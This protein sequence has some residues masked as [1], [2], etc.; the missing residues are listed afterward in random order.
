VSRPLVPVP[1]GAD[2]RLRDNE[3]KKKEETKAKQKQTMM[4]FFK[5][6]AA[7]PI[8]RASPAGPSSEP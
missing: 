2:S 3:A 5:K 1:H 4:S 7:S 6:P 8:S